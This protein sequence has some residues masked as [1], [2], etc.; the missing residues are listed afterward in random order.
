MDTDEKEW[1]DE[2]VERMRG[3][4]DA[5]DYSRARQHRADA[6]KT[7]GRALSRTA[8]ERLDVA[9]ALAIYQDPELPM[10]AR[11]VRAQRLVEPHLA[12][13]A[14][15]ET[16]GVA[17]AIERRFYDLDTRVEHLE[18]AAATY[19]R[20]HELDAENGWPSYGY[21]GINV[22]HLNDMIA[23]IEEASGLPI[24]I[25]TAAGRRERARAIREILLASVPAPAA[26]DEKKYWHRVTMAEAALGLGDLARAEDEIAK[27]LAFTP[28]PWMIRSTAVQLAARLRQQHADGRVSEQERQVL[29]ALVGTSVEA[30][31]SAIRGRLGLALSGGGF[32]A[33]FFHIGVLARLAE[34][35][36]LR[37]VE[38]LSCV[39]GGS[40][41]GA[42]YTL[43]IKQL[44]ESKAD[45]DIGRADFAEV[46]QR[47]AVRFCE[48]VQKNIRVRVAFNVSEN[49]AM[50]SG[51]KSRSHRIADLYERY[52]YARVGPS[53]DRRSDPRFMAELRI[54]PVGT[55]GFKPESDNW[56]RKNKVPHIVFNAA[57]LNTGHAW[58]FTPE[59]MG[60][61]PAREEDVDVNDRF[62]RLPYERFG[63][64]YRMPLGHAVAASACVPGLFEP[65]AINDVYGGPRPLLVDG[66]VHDN[67]GT[68]ALLERDCTAIIVSDASGQMETAADPSN[69]ALGSYMRSD[70]VFQARIREAQYQDLVARVQGNL[71]T[72][73]GFLHLKQEF[74]R[75]EVHPGRAPAD[76]Q[77]TVLSYG[78]SRAVQQR[79][80]ALRTDLDAFSSLEAEALMASGY[81]ITASTIHPETFAAS[82]PT[83]GSPP[84]KDR[85]TEKA[86]ETWFPFLGVRPLLTAGPGG[87]PTE[88]RVLQL[89]SAG[90]KNV[91][92]VF[93][94]DKV[95]LAAGWVA[96]AA[97][98]AGV[99]ALTW[100]YSDRLITHITLGAV[101]LMLGAS[102][103]RALRPEVGVVMDVLKP[104][105]VVTRFVRTIVMGVAGSL[106][107]RA[108]V[109]LADRS[110]LKAGR[111]S[112]L[113]KALADER[114]TGNRTVPPP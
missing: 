58:Q 38:V 69:A 101:A 8:T 36:L 65:L 107:A 13:S 72:G 66:G 27:A 100:T 86:V 113:L 80:A 10:R 5:R 46:V 54:E 98:G 97:A 35:D 24:P 59:V 56:R 77:S 99:V 14:D 82:P 95:A 74:S 105:N 89:L 112:P 96:L 11:L 68:A 44:Y 60:E 92:K 37:H 61:P 20:G 78:V 91:G 93:A 32:R 75:R 4:R 71:V 73:L 103:L 114:A 21:P 12:Q 85:F 94:V 15:P 42:L 62:V 90:E 55:S 17:G 9:L 87:T 33:A 111:V 70:S 67:Q 40:L 16:L 49:W 41:L 83:P 22:A 81:L 104:A 63:T 109:R 1:V 88:A 26:N 29:H 57:T 47:V 25:A 31:C 23:S 53:E 30:V 34:T 84:Q 51:R 39:S 64:A 102:V 52:L 18:R 2:V 76:D 3:L 7:S 45:V 106:I 108:H 79:L 110:F 19:S 28:A 6:E 43:E 50:L 48:E